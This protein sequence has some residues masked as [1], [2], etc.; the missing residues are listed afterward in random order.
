M[1]RVR[2]LKALQG[3]S[4]V[5]QTS[6]VPGEMSTGYEPA[7]QVCRRRAKVVSSSGCAQISP[8]P[9]AGGDTEY[10]PSSRLVMEPPRHCCPD[11]DHDHHSIGTLLEVEC[12]E[13]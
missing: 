10:E 9:V 2:P 7:L 6:S 1:L 11:S 12:D 3:P 4:R 5:A 13:S 8:L